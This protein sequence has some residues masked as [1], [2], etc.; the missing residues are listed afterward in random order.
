ML[1]LMYAMEYPKTPI[2]NTSN[3]F[4]IMNSNCIH[5]YPAS[6]LYRDDDTSSKM[7]YTS[8]YVTIGPKIYRYICLTNTYK[9]LFM[10]NKYETASSKT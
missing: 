5:L 2:E 3:S 7:Y 1:T 9:L 10:L 6:L 8:T 4:C